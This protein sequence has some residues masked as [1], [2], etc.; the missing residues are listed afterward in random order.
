VVMK[1]V[2]A[3]LPLGMQVC[4]AEMAR[5][6]GLNSSFETIA[7]KDLCCRSV[8]PAIPQDEAGVL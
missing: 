1:L 6:S 5:A 8:L 2:T 3:R 4:G 7:T